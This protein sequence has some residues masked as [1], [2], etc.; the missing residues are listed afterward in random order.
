MVFKKTKCLESRD[1]AGWEDIMIWPECDFGDE[2]NDGHN[3]LDVTINNNET[4][5][6]V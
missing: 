1:N 5:A 6:D 3:G 2:A 4:D